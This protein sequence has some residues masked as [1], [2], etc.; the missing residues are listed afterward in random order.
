[1]KLV[2]TSHPALDTGLR[3]LAAD[4]L[5]RQRNRSRR[6]SQRRRAKDDGQRAA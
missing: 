5:R 1:M 6:A 4:R 2:H 3:R